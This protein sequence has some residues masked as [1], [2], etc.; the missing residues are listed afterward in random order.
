MPVFV[1]SNVIIDVI[2]ADPVW[3]DWSLG[4]LEFF[5]K[6]GVR[7]YINTIIY[8]EVATCFNTKKDA[9][10]GLRF[11]NTLP[12]NT[13]IAFAAGDAFKKYR[14]NNRQ[15]PSKKQSNKRLILPDFDIGAHATKLRI[16]LLTRNAKDFRCF[17]GLKLISPVS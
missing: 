12:L 3:K 16:P 9:D 11:F 10:H 2:I 15:L 7:L 1:D 14:L 6:K 5:T 17:K 8:S 13:E 4:M